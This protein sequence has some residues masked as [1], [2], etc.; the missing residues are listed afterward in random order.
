[1]GR[2][3]A[4]GRRRHP[5][6]LR[7]SRSPAGPRSRGRL[8]GG[9]R[10]TRRTPRGPA[11]R[12][13]PRRLLSGTGA[14]RPL[15]AVVDAPDVRRVPRQPRR[16]P[17]R[18]GVRP[19]HGP[20]PRR[21]QPP[22]DPQHLGALPRPAAPAGHRPRPPAPAAAVGPGTGAR[23]VPGARR[24]ATPR[25][26]Q[27]V[28]CAYGRSA[29]G[30]GEGPRR[31]PA[32]HHRDD[33]RVHRP[34]EEPSAAL[35][36][37][38]PDGP[39]RLPRPCR[40][41]H[42]D[43]PA[44]APRHRTAEELHPPPRHLRP[45]GLAPLAGH[46]PALRRGPDPAARGRPSGPGPGC[47]GH[48]A[49]RTGRAVPQRPRNVRRS[50]L[51]PRHARLDP[52][53]AARPRP[54]GHHRRRPPSGLGGT[55]H[56]RPHRGGPAV[57]GG[58]RGLRTRPAGRPRLPPVGE[59]RPGPGTARAGTV[60]GGGGGITGRPGHAPA[61]RDPPARHPAHPARPGDPRPQTRPAR[62]GRHGTAVRI[63]GDQGAG[64]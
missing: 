20:G 10:R 41:H 23:P 50:H 46:R 28:Q 44:A 38:P 51:R 47:R 40:L 56:R 60:R 39:G 8:G 57:P 25:R 31:P 36:H 11:P 37:H 17:L 64:R 2:L 42:P 5:L 19:R 32:D 13:Q 27:V 45:Q 14:G 43:T 21:A 63:E 7:R 18:H 22:R 61:G 24:T 29:Q 9:G 1:M 12:P 55:P 15:A 48:R 30:G 4:H 35:D 3:G 6:R 33:P 34:G 58:G 16:P 54:P 53:P 49:G 59:D 52:G 62:G 26:E